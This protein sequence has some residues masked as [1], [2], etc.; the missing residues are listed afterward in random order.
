MTTETVTGLLQLMPGKGF[1]FLRQQNNHYMPANGDPFVVP[2][3]V[4]EFNLREGVLVTGTTKAGR[5]PGQI[6]VD[7]ISEIDGI[8]PEK[9]KD[10]PRFEDL[11]P[12]NPKDQFKME[13]VGD[14][15]TTRVL[16]LVAP[17]GKGQ[18]GLIVAPPRTG[19]T[20]LLQHIADGI[21]KN[22]PEAHLIVLLIDERPE[23]VTEMKRMIQGEVVA[24]SSDRQVKDHVAIAQLMGERAKRLVE[25]GKDVVVLLDSITRLGRAFNHASDTGRTLSGGLD[26][27]AMEFPRRLF[28]SARQCEDGGSLTILATALIDTGS[29]MDQ[30]IFEEFKGTGNMELVLDRSIAERRVWPAIDINKSGTRREELILSKEAYDK[31]ILVRRALNGLKPVDAMELLL[32]KMEATESN[33]DFFKVLDKDLD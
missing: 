7:Q 27:R 14:R 3:L 23:E 11:T 21:T 19:K 2:E 17:I 13:T 28:G 25:Q 30:V 6:Q 22:F 9:F 20:I 18:R 26:S 16:D 31:A 4:R 29:R 10:F 24:S 33:D 12:L 32:K 15:M 8:K 5:K 1:G